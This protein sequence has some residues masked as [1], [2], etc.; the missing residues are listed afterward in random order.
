MKTGVPIQQLDRIAFSPKEFATA[1]GLSES[2]VLRAVRT[3]QIRAV[4]IGRRLLIPASEPSRLLSKE[5]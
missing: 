4:R 1:S 2:A 3:G 5:D